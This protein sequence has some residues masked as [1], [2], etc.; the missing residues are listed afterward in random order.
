MI[1]V[2]VTDDRR[3][4][5]RLSEA[6]TIARNRAE[7]RQAAAVLGV[8]EVIDLEYQTDVLGD[9]SEVGLRE[10]IIRLVRRYRPFALVT[11]DPYAM[12]GEDN[13]DHKLVAEA[14]DEAFWTSQFDLHHPEQLADGLAPHGCFGAQRERI[15]RRHLKR[16][17]GSF[18][19]S[20]LYSVLKDEW[21]EVKAGLTR[22]LSA[23]ASAIG[24]PAAYC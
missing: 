4:S 12:H 16:E 19:D 5:F 3:D 11:F 14:T 23:S 2:R 1:A 6:E 20:V 10:R 24:P 21:P 9:A 13:Q 15:L 22:R 7:L 8:S 18:R 17:D